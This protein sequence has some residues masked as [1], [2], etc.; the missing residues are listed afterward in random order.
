MT[1]PE[2]RFSGMDSAFSG[3]ALDPV[4]CSLLSLGEKR[5]LVHEIARWSKDAP[6]FLRSF[7][8]SEL[9]EIIC[10]E[11]GKERKATLTS[12]DAFCKRCSCC[13]CHCYDDNKDP[14]LWLTCDNDLCGLSCHLECALK[15]ERAGILKHGCC[16]K[17]DGS[18][19]C[20]SCGKINGIMRTW[21]KQLIVAKEAR[22]VDVLC[23][24]LSL[25][26]KILMGTAL[27][28]EVQ[29]TVESAVK[30]LN[31]EVGPLDQVCTSMVRCIVNRLSCGA[32][33]QKLC[34]SAVLSFD[35]LVCPNYME[36]KDPFA[37]H[38]RFEEST[39]T[40]VIVVLEY[41]DHL[42]KNNPGCRLW[43]RESVIKDYPE[44]PT[45]IVFRPEKRFKICHLHPS[46]EYLCK[47][48]LFSSIGVLGVSEAKWE[49]PAPGGSSF[50]ALE[51]GKAEHRIIAQNHPQA[52]STKSS[53]FKSASPAKLQ[54]LVEINKSKSE[55]F[56]YPPPFIETVSPS[57]PCKCSGMRAVPDMG[58]KMRP[59]VSDYEHSVQVVRGLEYE[60]HIDEDF[61][62][63]FLTWFSLKATEQERRVV[64]VFVDAL[65]DD[66]PSLA[67]QLMDTFMDKICCEQ[68]PVSRHGFCFSLW[69]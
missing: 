47:V 14:S 18:F 11:M 10:A 41:E 28:K 27:Y 39:P 24:R 25:A 42:L 56:Y 48:S 31:D 65:L 59:L 55:G 16:E 21:R 29:R 67:G 50:T 43:H 13:I 40:S 69:H 62:V 8:R 32:E 3:C 34:A 36:K 19:Y 63:K 38:I 33:V 58:S 57:T 54:P 66:P 61:R 9:L 5:E 53:N 30:I 35:S 45:F 64:N 1:K 2:E 49:T 37:C 22:R 12:E 4:K 23:L 7:T 68:K 26:H 60:G 6:E 15:H 44:Q 20:I 17:L 46:T 51:H 52:E